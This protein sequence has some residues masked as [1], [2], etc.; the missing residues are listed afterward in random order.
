MIGIYLLV[1]LFTQLAPQNLWMMESG[2]AEV[3]VEF[4]NISGL[5]I[6]SAVLAEGRLIGNVAS[7]APISDSTTGIKL[8]SDDSRA[9]R[10]GVKLSPHHRTLIR[11]GTIALIKSPLSTARVA[12]E[13]VIELLIPSDQGAPMLE[14]GERIVGYSSF[15]EFWSADFSARGLSASSFELS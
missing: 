11:R 8:A 9:Y 3:A 5:K 15:E 4:E 14:S 7:I 13:A 6:G 12:P 1:T 10:V 2:P